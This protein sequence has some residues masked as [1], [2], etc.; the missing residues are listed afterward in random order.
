HAHLKD[1]KAETLRASS[2]LIGTMMGG[3]LVLSSFI[4]DFPAVAELLFQQ[5]ITYGPDGRSR[6]PYSDMLALLGAVLL[7]APLV[8]NAIRGLTQGHNHMDE[9]VALAVVAAIALG[10]YKEAGIIAF[11]MVISNLIETRT[12]LGARASIE[13]LLR[14][15]PETAH[16]ILPDGSEE[17]VE[18]SRLSPGEI[19][20]VRPGDN[21]PADG[22]IIAG[23]ST[24]NQANIT[25]ESLPVDKTVG[26]EVFSGTNN[27]TGQLDIRVTKAGRDT[28]LGRVQDLILGAEGTRIPVMRL[29]DQY[30]GWYTPT[31]CMLAGIVWFFA[32]DKSVGVHKAITMLII[33]CPC[34]LVLAT[35]TAMVAALSCAARLG[36]LIKNV[37]QLEYARSLTAVVFDKTGT[38]TT[39]VLSVTQ[40]KPAPGVDGADLLHAAASAEQMSKHPAAKAMVEVAKRAKIELVTPSSFKETAGLGVTAKLD[41]DE[42]LVGRSSWLADQGTDVSLTNDPE[43]AEPDGISTVY[44]AR[45]GKC[46]GWIGLEDRT[47][48]EARAAIDELRKLGVHN[49]TMVTGDKWSVARRVGAEMGCTEVQAEVLPEDKLRLVADLQRRGHRVAV[50]GDGVN[51]APMLAASDLGI[52][53]GAAGS[54]VA[55]NS[56]SIALMNNDLSRL[57]FLIRLSKGSMA[58][59]RQNIIF[60]VAF[61]VVT[62]TLAV[63]GPLTPITAAIAHT[64]ATAFVIFNSARLVRFGEERTPHQ[65]QPAAAPPVRPPGDRST[66]ACGVTRCRFHCV[67]VDSCRLSQPKAG[68]PCRCTRTWRRFVWPWHPTTHQRHLCGTARGA[69]AP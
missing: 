49:L 57:P 58:V 26:G 59:V 40:M 67:L 19:I 10:D 62:M 33:A 23:E 5:A 17:V 16:R 30:A 52:A 65:D 25:G 44:V 42:I 36:I 6:N 21:V 8:W 3:M 69:V 56:A 34:A 54:D 43:Y 66:R 12:A 47:R 9:L 51:D 1:I 38:L 39:G 61:I 13:S 22:E 31:V 4:V 27:L 7:G 41:D 32:E 55:I 35:P 24:I 50:V 45:N 14:L 11:F 46:L 15:T 28:T 29:I 2:L 37:V 18:A 68:V 63:W 64:I 48:D 53:M 20:R 60:G